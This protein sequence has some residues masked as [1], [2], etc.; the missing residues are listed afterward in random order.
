[1][2]SILK[3][4]SVVGLLCATGCATVPSPT[5][6]AFFT[7]IGYGMG[8]RKDASATAVF[9]LSIHSDAPDVM[10]I[11]G[12]LPNPTQPGG[13]D[14]IRKEVKKSD[15]TVRFEG[16]RV[17]GWKDR[18]VYTYVARVYADPNYTKLLATHIQKVRCFKPTEAMLSL[19]KPS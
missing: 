1:M 10:Y 11:E 17:S 12:V 4:V 2:K 9:T 16:P 5:R 8:W 6:T 19:L 14:V 7:T 18:V 3:L 15:G 13:K